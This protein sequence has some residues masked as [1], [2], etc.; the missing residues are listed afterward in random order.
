MNKLKNL[1]I[2]GAGGNAEVIASTVH[3]IN[4]REEEWNLK[5]FFDDNP[6][7]EMSGI[8]HCGQ[9]TKESIDRVCCNESYFVWSL[10]SVK[11]MDNLVGRL[12]DLGIDKNKFAT[13]I[14]PTAIV[15]KSAC[16]GNGV[17]IHPLCVIGPGVKIDDH[18]MIFGQGFIG[19]GAII[20][21]FS[22]I[23]NNAS[24]GAR[25]KLLQGAY[26]GTNSCIREN[27]SVG[28]WSVVG[29]GSVVLNDVEDYVTVV[30]AP[31][32]ELKRDR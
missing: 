29:M 23:A 7:A 6:N 10:M 25:V 26:I 8:S 11:I 21:T 24:I 18:S 22:Y 5:G 4:T 13:L 19:H 16:I 27:V 30:G 31:A 17:T 12:Q 20:G 2:I 1:Y 28:R 32:R 3:D 14:H 15:S 9:I